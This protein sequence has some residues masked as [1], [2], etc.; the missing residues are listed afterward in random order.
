MLYTIWCIVIGDTTLFSVNIDE[1]K[2]VDALKQVIKKEE[3]PR[4]DAFAAHELTLYKIKE[5]KLEESGKY[6]EAVQEISQNLSKQTSLDPWIEL[7]TI[8][9]GFPNCMLHILIEPPAG[10]SIQ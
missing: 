5:A 9:G 6:L 8:E 10:E 3:E 2:S 7:S 1:T 4:F